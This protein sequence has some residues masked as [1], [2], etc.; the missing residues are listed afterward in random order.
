MF[1]ELIFDDSELLEDAGVSDRSLS[2][3]DW[4]DCF[5]EDLMRSDDC[6]LS[7]SLAVD[8]SGNLYAGART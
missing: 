5:A 1:V 8:L 6:G 7:S 4:L 3:D 2:C